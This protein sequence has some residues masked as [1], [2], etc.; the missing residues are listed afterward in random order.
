MTRLNTAVV[1]AR[2]ISPEA[3]AEVAHEMVRDV[4]LRVYQEGFEDG[5]REPEYDE[6]GRL[7]H[8]LFGAYVLVCPAHKKGLQMVWPQYLESDYCLYLEPT[9]LARRL[10]IR[11]GRAFHIRFSSVVD[12]GTLLVFE[13]GEQV[14]EF[15]NKTQGVL[16]EFDEG[17]KRYF[18]LTFD[19]IHKWWDIWH[20]HHTF[21]DLYA[22]CNRGF[23]DKSAIEATGKTAA[24]LVADFRA[25]RLPKD[26]TGYEHIKHLS[27]AWALYDSGKFRS[28]LFELATGDLVRKIPGVL[29]KA[30]REVEP[31][32][33][34]AEQKAYQEAYREALE[35]HR[36]KKYGPKPERWAF[37]PEYRALPFDERKK[38]CQERILLSQNWG[39]QNWY[40]REI[41]GS[42]F[43]LSE[44]TS[45]KVGD[46]VVAAA[47][48]GRVKAGEYLGRIKSVYLWENDGLPYARVE[49]CRRHPTKP[50][51]FEN[52]VGDATNLRL[53]TP[54]E[55]EA[56]QSLVL[57]DAELADRR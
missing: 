57:S 2:T 28:R 22:P 31:D 29:L 10:S 40:V 7:K 54:E 12:I 24:E 4:I 9:E 45:L 5:S 47:D 49:V 53:A 16:T 34:F 56:N 52:F 8:P 41:I 43:D 13:N 27:K 50:E 39:C 6:E 19:Q 1:D 38:L 33:W 21:N 55:I 15:T 30:P 35:R 36:T 18:G 32:W 25:G 23:W 37:D 46:H 51:W 44:F 26:C 42:L 3:I 48:D 17:L 11:A 14:A 20:Y